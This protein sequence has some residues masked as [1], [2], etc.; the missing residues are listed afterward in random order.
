MTESTLQTFGLL[1]VAIPSVGCTTPPQ[2]SKRASDS[3]ESTTT[4]HPTDLDGSEDTSH[5]SGPADTGDDATPNPGDLLVDEDADGFSSVVDCDDTDPSRYPG[6]PEVCHD[7]VVNDCAG[8][9]WLARVECDS[10][11]TRTEALSTWS[12]STS[13]L[14]AFR[15]RSVGDIDGDGYDDIAVGEP[16]FSRSEQSVGSIR[17]YKGPFSGVYSLGDEDVLIEGEER[18]DAI[19]WDIAPMGDLDDDGYDDFAVGG[20]DS[21]HSGEYV[22][23]TPSVYVVHGPGS[24]TRI[25]DA[26]MLVDASSSQECLGSVLEPFPDADDDG[27]ADILVGGRCDNVVRLFSGSTPSQIPGADDLATFRGPDEEGRFG[28]A[29]AIGDLDGDGQVDVAI[30]NPDYHGDTNGSV[31]VFSSPP[32]ATAHVEDASA[33]IQSTD[34]DSTNGHLLLGSGV[35]VGDLN[36]DGH[37][38]LAAGAPLWS[39]SPT[40]GSVEGL[41]VV[42]FGPLSGTYTIYDAGFRMS[43]DA[44]YQS[45]GGEMRSGQ[46]LDGDG[47]DDLL[48]AN[49][50]NE[51]NGTGATGYI[52]GN[53]AYVLRSPLTAGTWTGIDADHV[54]VDTPTTDPFGQHAT[55]A[56]DSDGDGVAEVL[57]GNWFG[58]IHLFHIP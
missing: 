44:D 46:D 57:V 36:G 37:D 51:I 41:L 14:D 56:G 49:G 18:K 21:H 32:L 10:L 48:V 27:V 16:L 40:F 52:R 3:P 25:G 5:D 33:T 39:D 23:G 20:A 54:L 22:S 31:S 38:D 2:S 7:S 28:H 15:V 42:Y 9:V 1:L 11:S 58:T 53:A 35:A 45:I 13:Q 43:G 29:I 12:L 26:L 17:V 4:S 8:D 47:A 6:A 19:G 34:E 55:L 30:G 24:L 50:Y